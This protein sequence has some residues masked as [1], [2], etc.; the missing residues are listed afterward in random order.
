MQK[1][2]IQRAETTHRQTCNGT[3]AT[4]GFHLEIAFDVGNEFIKEVGHILHVVSLIVVAIENILTVGAS[5]GTDNNHL[6]AT[7]SLGCT[8]VGIQHTLSHP[9][10][11]V[12]V[13]T[14]Q[15]VEHGILRPITA[16]SICWSRIS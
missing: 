11:V 5:V 12:A 6:L 14:M 16:L 10:V 4:S 2:V 13:G 1:A 15:Q 3:C 8:G 9:V 7:R